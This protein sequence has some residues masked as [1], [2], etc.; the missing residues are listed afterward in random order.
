MGVGNQGGGR[1]SGNKG[2]NHNF[3]HRELQILGSQ[4]AALGLLAT[5]STLVSV[6]NAIVASDQDIEILLVRDTG[7][8]NEVVQQI[9]NYETGVPV[10]SYKDVNDT[11]YVPVGPLEYLDPSGVMSLVLAELLAQGLTL[12]SILLD[13][14]S[15][16]AEDFATEATLTALNTAFGLEDF[17]TETT[18]AGIKTQTDLLNFIAT[19][20]EVTVTSTVLPTGAATEA[21]LAA[22]EAKFNT[23][24]QKASAASAPVV[25]STEQEA[26][27]SGISAAITALG[28]GGLATEATLLLTNGLL[29]TIDTVLDSIALDTANLDVLLSTR[30]SEAT[31]AAQA[32]DVAL[33]EGYLVGVTRTPTLTNV[34]GVA[35]A[36][37]AAGARSVSFFNGGPVDAT[38]AGG[39]LRPGTSVSFAAG[40]EEDT[41]GAIAYVTIATGILDITT[42]V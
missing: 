42:I 7:N 35:G 36:S 11:A 41:L 40:G 30:A 16:A 12:D 2:S 8:S 34:L 24:G 26:I 28:T 18:L 15:L 6:L 19:A 38:V 3:E 4:L 33:I 21:T 25:L 9:T 39:T 23:L 13:T 1:N 37:V 22:L 27:L 5:E 31:L 14:T 32:A 20:L 29:T 10:I 17:A